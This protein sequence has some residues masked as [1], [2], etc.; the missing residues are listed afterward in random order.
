MKD[1]LIRRIFCECKTVAVVGLSNRPGRPSFAVASYLKEKGFRII[2]V[3]P[4][5]AEALG[6]KSFPSLSAIPFP[7]DVVDIFRRPEEV[8]PIVEEAI[9][10]RAKAVWLQEGISS[11]L[12]E[13][14]AEE[15]GLLVV[16]DRCMLKE[17]RR[18]FAP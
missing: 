9:R 16:S 2:P 1:D 17:H 5:I 14:K 3:N 7:V 8:L 4:T 18:L 12:A 11:P 15:A 10:I 6:E 13:K